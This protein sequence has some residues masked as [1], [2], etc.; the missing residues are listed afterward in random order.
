MKKNKKTAL[1][2]GA[3]RGIGKTIAKTLIKQG[4]QIIGTSTTEDGVEKIN[5]YSKKNGFGIILNLKNTDSIIETMKEIYKKQYSIDILINNA[6]IKKDNL[7]I[8]MTKTEWEDVIQINLSSVFYLV[9]S[10]IGSMIRKRQGRIITIGS[11]IANIGNKGQVNYSASKSGLIGLHKSLA[12]EVASKGITVNIISPGFINTNFTNTLSFKQYQKYLSNI[13]VK[14]TGYKEEIAHAVIF[15][16]SN[17]AS[18][19][20]GHTLHINGGMYMM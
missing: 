5:N 16:T 12:L 10:V 11:I 2:T 19:I 9:K 6:G 13:P 8:K 7:L 14:R 3:N 17:K 15:L 20:T 18:Y 4:I 1:I